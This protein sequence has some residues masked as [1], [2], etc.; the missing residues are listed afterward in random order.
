MLGAHC[1]IEISLA[2]PQSDILDRDD[3][4]KNLNVELRTAL[5]QLPFSEDGAISAY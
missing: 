5:T 4:K 2:H 1:A 3:R